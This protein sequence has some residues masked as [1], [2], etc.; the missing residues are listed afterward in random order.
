MTIIQNANEPLFIGLDVTGSMN[1]A[2]AP[3]CQTRLAY[4]IQRLDDLLSRLPDTT[5]VTLVTVGAGITELCLAQSPAV[6]KAQL[7]DL[8]AADAMCHTGMLLERCMMCYLRGQQRGTLLL[9]TDGMP[10]DPVRY[11]A[12]KHF[13]ALYESHLAIHVLTL[14]HTDN[15]VADQLFYIGHAPR[16]EQKRSDYHHVNVSERHSYAPLRDSE[17]MF[18]RPASA[19][20]EGGDAATAPTQPPSVAPPTPAPREDKPTEYVAP[21]KHAPAATRTPTSSPK[22]GSK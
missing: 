20:P 9:I 15:P 2:D 17:L 8:T 7:A 13:N 16:Y 19:P 22:R 6:A 14:G 12:W 3:E 1:I 18:G 11:E 21:A 10:S 4:A 5:E